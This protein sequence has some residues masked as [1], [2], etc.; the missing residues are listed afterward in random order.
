[1]NVIV[2]GG[3]LGSGKTSLLLQLARFLTQQSQNN[4]SEPSLVIIE[5]EIGETGIDEKVLRSDGLDV[6]EL[7][8]GCICCTL[9]ADL[10]ICLNEIQETLSP[11]WVIIEATGM[12]YPHKIIETLTSYGKGID[13]LKTLVV[14]DAERWDELSTVITG[15]IEGQIKN[16][17]IIL[18][19]KIDCLDPLLLSC[20]EE[21]V[22]KL[23]PSALFYS[24]S[25][26]RG[27][28]PKIWSEVVSSL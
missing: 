16:A 1:M 26:N 8:S 10:T 18:L 4:G 7:F 27:I 2:L 19:N 14:V 17:D 3:F 21:N 25:S 23:N 5:N 11:K 6:R 15:L 9:T 20:V 22:I 12:A 13:R 28:D 24:V